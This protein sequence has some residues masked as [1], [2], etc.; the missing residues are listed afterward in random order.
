MLGITV[1]D[2]I[3]I[4]ES[5]RAITVHVHSRFLNGIRIQLGDMI[6]KYGY[7][8]IGVSSLREKEGRGHRCQKNE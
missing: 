3:G 6:N 7:Q 4:I 5:V 2:L 1:N 8:F